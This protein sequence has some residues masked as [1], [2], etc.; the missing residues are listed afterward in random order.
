MRRAALLLTLA[1][2]LAFAAKDDRTKPLAIESERGGTVNQ[3]SGRV[4]WEGPVLL[5]HGLHDETAP[6]ADAQRLEAASAGRAP[7][8]PVDA[9]HDLGESLGPHAD[10]IVGFLRSALFPRAA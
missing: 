1:C 3:Q 2:G 9:G 7:V 10:A 8:L 4:E 6:F 5:V